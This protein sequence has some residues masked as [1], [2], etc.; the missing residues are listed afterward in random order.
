MLAREKHTMI[1]QDLLKKIRNIEIHTRRLLSGTQV[2]DYSTALKGSGF[3]FDQIREYQAG[4]DVR[5]IDWKSTARMNKMLVRQYL[6]ERNRTI[7]L[8]VDTSASTKFGSTE[9]L[10]SELM[11][12]IAGVLALVADYGKDT[13][14]LIH[15][16]D[17]LESYMPPARGRKHVHDIMQ[18]LFTQ[19]SVIEQN[20]HVSSMP[21][22]YHEVAQLIASKH[23]KSIIFVISDFIDTESFIESIGRT[24]KHSQVIAVRCL[25]RIERKFPPV[26][27]LA[28]HELQGATSNFFDMSKKSNSSY[29]VLLEERLKNQD[30]LFKKYNVDLFDAV[31]GTPFMH[32]LINF[33][34]RRMMY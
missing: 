17:K 21:A 13:V 34:R 22:S 10:K 4:D 33:F 6:E 15:Y 19:A 31:P 28:M 26:G 14:G 32:D 18:R 2:G 9:T 30:K 25:D 8:M 1:S 27:I 11:A 20:K 12:Q 23:K 5:F 24:T 7:V 16:S 29:N 3:E